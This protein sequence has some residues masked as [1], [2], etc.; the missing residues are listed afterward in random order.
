[1]AVIEVSVREGTPAA[2]K[3]ADA[4]GAMGADVTV[5]DGVLRATARTAPCVVCAAMIDATRLQHRD[6]LGGE[7]CP[8]CTQQC[9]QV[10]STF[11]Q[12]ALRASHEL[13]GQLPGIIRDLRAGRDMPTFYRGFE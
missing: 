13:K 8:T 2:K 6:A 11:K 5:R 3:M 10:V 7:A 12:A 1:M 4:L 9:D